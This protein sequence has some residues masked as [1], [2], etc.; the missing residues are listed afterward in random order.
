MTSFTTIIELNDVK[1]GDYYTLHDEMK[2]RGFSR[3]IKGSDA[4]YQLP[5]ATYNYSGEIDA[6]T[7]YDKAMQAV[8]ALGRS[9]AIVVTQ[10]AG[11]VIGGLARA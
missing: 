9:A 5:A 11:R 2:R 3:T 10:S 4:E 7:V 6:Q 1:S 8:T